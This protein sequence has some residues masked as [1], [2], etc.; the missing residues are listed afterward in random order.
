MLTVDC[1]VMER[2]GIFK[3][4]HSTWTCLKTTWDWPYFQIPHSGTHT[5]TSNRPRRLLPCTIH[6]LGLFRS[7]HSLSGCSCLR[8]WALITYAVGF[9]YLHSFVSTIPSGAS[10]HQLSRIAIG[11][12][13]SG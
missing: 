6:G 1:F 11:N 13:T 12:S 2:T 3:A 4:S 10:T 9:Q 5:E 8:T 7:T